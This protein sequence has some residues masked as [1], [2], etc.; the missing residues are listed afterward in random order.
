MEEKIEV[1]E[2]GIFFGITEEEIEENEK[3]KEG[4]E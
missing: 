2:E 4:E 1:I 3:R